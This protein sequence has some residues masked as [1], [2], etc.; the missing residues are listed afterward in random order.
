MEAIATPQTFL[1]A[2]EIDGL[3]DD[4]LA[5]GTVAELAARYKVHRST[6]SKHLTGNGVAR[7]S[8]G[9]HRWEAAE[10]VR[11]FRQGESLRGISRSIG[12]SRDSVRKTLERYRELPQLACRQSSTIEQSLPWQRVG[13]S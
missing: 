8:A 13:V 12:A 11:L 3:V 2:A 9:L 7:R 1:S 6:V 5:G 10:A 4:Y